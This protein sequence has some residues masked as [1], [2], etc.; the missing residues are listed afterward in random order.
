M[1]LIKQLWSFLLAII[2]ICAIIIALGIMFPDGELLA[3]LVQLG[4]ALQNL[5]SAVGDALSGAA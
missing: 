3:G 2:G 4:E 1:A 5:F